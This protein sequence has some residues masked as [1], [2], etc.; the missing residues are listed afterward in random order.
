MCQNH[1]HNGQ[2]TL[3]T[4]ID[5]VRATVRFAIQVGCHACHRHLGEDDPVWLNNEVDTRI[6]TGTNPNFQK[7]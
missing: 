2:N 3:N 6:Q 4:I 7:L 1:M 5:Y